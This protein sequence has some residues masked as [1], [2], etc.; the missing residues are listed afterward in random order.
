MP[1]LTVIIISWKMKAM[2]HELLC[3]ITQ[4][5]S[6]IAYEVIVVDNHSGDGTSE[7]IRKEFPSAIL[8]ENSRNRGV[9]PARN[10]ALSRANGRYVLLLDADMLLVE[11]SIKQLVDFMGRT[12]DAGICACTLVSPDGVVQPTARRYPSLLVFALR[13]LAFIRAVRR[14]R[15]LNRHE[16]TDWD[17]KE[18][19]DVDYVIGACQLIRREALSQVGL[20]DE[21]IFYGPEDIDYCLRMYK[22]G[23]KV[24]YYPHTRIVHYEQRITKKK[25]F[26]KLSILHLRGIMYLFFKYG[27]VLSRG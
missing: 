7:M 13:R 5:T 26:S 14:S 24:Y 4:H 23:W 21:K 10:Q 17:R 11:N 22:S 27:G 2:L 25:I 15:T 12:E 8:I 19:R 18:T 20:L 6:G 16:M 9:A 1:D 3:S